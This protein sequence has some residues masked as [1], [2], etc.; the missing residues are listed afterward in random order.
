MT[1]IQFPAIDIPFDWSNAQW[2]RTNLPHVR[3]AA[4]LL[5]RDDVRLTETIGRMVEAG[6][7]N[8]MLDGFCETKDH[9]KAVVSLLDAALTRSFIALERLGFTPDAP[10]ETPDLIAA[11]QAD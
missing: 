4:M 6:I 5:R 11:A 1:D 7:V 3:I 8:E 2:A 10:P 9:L